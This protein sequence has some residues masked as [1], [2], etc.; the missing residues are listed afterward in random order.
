MI[1][2]ALDIL[3]AGNAPRSVFVDYPLGHTVGRPFDRA[4]QRASVDDALAAFELIT[5]PGEIVQLD[6]RWSDNDAWKKEASNTKGSDTR[7]PRDST[8]QYQTDT[9]RIAAAQP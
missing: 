2:S 1:G 9:D 6:Y 3:E 7:S 5:R 8:P 4:N